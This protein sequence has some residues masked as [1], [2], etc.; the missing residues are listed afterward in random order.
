MGKEH[1]EPVTRNTTDN[2]PTLQLTSPAKKH[3]GALQ[4]MEH[5]GM[6]NYSSTEGTSSNKNL[7][8]V[9]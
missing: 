4:E 5:M 7:F 2:S 1:K 3:T 8:R 9:C 6:R